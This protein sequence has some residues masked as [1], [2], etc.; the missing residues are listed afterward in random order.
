M[1]SDVRLCFF[2]LILLCC[3]FDE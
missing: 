1:S 3:Q 2:V